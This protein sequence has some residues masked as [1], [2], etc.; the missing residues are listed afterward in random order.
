MYFPSFVPLL[1][2][3]SERKIEIIPTNQVCSWCYYFLDYKL[4]AQHHFN[5]MWQNAVVDLQCRNLRFLEKTMNQL[6]PAWNNESCFISLLVFL[7]C[8]LIF[9]ISSLIIPKG[10]KQTPTMIQRAKKTPLEQLLALYNTATLV[11]CSFIRSNL[12]GILFFAILG[13]F[14]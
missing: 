10:W 1:V 14:Y 13:L 2:I 3:W 6:F 8:I 11:D 4:T 5:F 12:K 9:Y 7:L